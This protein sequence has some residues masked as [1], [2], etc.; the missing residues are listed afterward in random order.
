MPKP[1]KP[2]I[3][4]SIKLREDQ[5]EYIKAVGNVSE[6]IR[7]AIDTKMAL[8]VG[9][10][11]VAVVQRLNA[12]HQQK[13]LILENPTY[14]RALRDGDS[15]TPESFNETVE[16]L[17]SWEYLLFKVKG[18][19]CKAECSSHIRGDPLPD[20]S[21]GPGDWKYGT[22]DH[23][24]GFDPAAVY[25]FALEHGFRGKKGDEWSYGM[26]KEF[27][28]ELIELLKITYNHDVKVLKA[29]QCRLAEIDDEIDSLRRNTL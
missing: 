20:G 10:D 14:R 2:M 28:P 8:E 27:M 5:L 21:Y 11:A 24:P 18:G 25:C 3:G 26:P 13:K 4:V 1:K 7:D 16:M 23:V 29:L 19:T 22:I 9:G 6:W 12:L 15:F 17:G